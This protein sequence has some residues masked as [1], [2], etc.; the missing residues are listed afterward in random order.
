MH[1]CR[2]RT[3]NILHSSCRFDSI[4]TF[5][6]RF[7]YTGHQL[8]ASHTHRRCPPRT[9]DPNTDQS[10]SNANAVE[11]GSG[12]TIMSYVGICGEDQN[13]VDTD[14][15]RDADPY[16][17]STSLV[18]MRSY[19]EG[20]VTTPNCGN[21]ATTIPVTPPVVE[22]LM[23]DPNDTCMVPVGSYVQ[24]S[25][26]ITST[27]DAST[28]YFAWDRIDP[29]REE[30][31]DRTV[32]RWVP[33]TPYP[34]EPIRYLP[35]LYLTTFET[36]L[37]DADQYEEIVPQSPIDM[38]F[39]FIARTQYSETDLIQQNE[40]AAALAGSFGFTDITLSYVNSDTPLQF[41]AVPASVTSFGSETVTWTGGTVLSP[42]V[43]ILIARNTMQD[44]GAN[45]NYEYN[46][47]V[48]FLEWISIG[49]FPNTGSAS[50]N[51]PDFQNNPSLPVSLMIRSVDATNTDLDTPDCYFFDM[52]SS[53][54]YANGVGEVTVSLAPSAVPTSSP[55]TSVAP[56]IEPT[57]VPSLSSAPS[58]SPT[59]APSSSIAPS[60]SP[61]GVPSSTPTESATESVQPSSS[62]TDSP[63][64]SLVPSVTP[65]GVPTISPS[66]PPSASSHPSSLPTDI[67]TLSSIP[68]SSPTDTPTTS[69]EPSDSPTVSVAPSANSAAPSESP[70]ISS[71][72]SPQP[73]ISP[74]SA[75]SDSPSQSP[76][77]SFNPT[78]LPTDEPSVQPSLSPTREPT[79][80]P[81]ASPTLS[82]QPSDIPTSQPSISLQ[83]SPTPTDIPTTSPSSQPSETPTVSSAPS[84][85]SD[86]PSEA[87]T[88][89]AQPS[90]SAGP[91][92]SPS[93][94]PSIS[95]PPSV[96]PTLNPTESVQPST[97][98]SS[99]PTAVPTEVP[100]IPPTSLPTISPSDQ[101]TSSIAPSQ[102]PTS[103]AAPTI[104]PSSGPTVG[105]LCLEPE[106][107]CSSGFGLSKSAN[108]R[109]LRRKNGK[110]SSKGKS[111]KSN[112]DQDGDENIRLFPI[113]VA[114]RQG[115]KGMG[116][117]GRRARR[118]NDTNKSSKGGK[119]GDGSSM[120]DE[121]SDVVFETI[122]ISDDDY[123]A[124]QGGETSNPVVSRGGKGKSSSLASLQDFT[125]G[126]CEAAQEDDVPEFCL[127]PPICADNSFPCSPNDRRL[128]RKSMGSK[129]KSKG[130]G[131][132]DERSTSICVNG[133]TLCVDIYDPEYL[134]GMGFSCGPCS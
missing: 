124:L 94:S 119:G 126:C 132:Q 78:N 88:V 37:N 91:T 64:L 79:T 74:T 24:L 50:I 86:A 120:D 1:T 117:M 100:S 95:N 89:S 58:S 48:D 103:S 6:V 69:A 33:Q 22:A 43:E 83:P 56:S 106:V 40:Y 31:S 57:Q 13:G 36:V 10:L 114:S 65:T 47:D 101:P 81:S 44:A 72:P 129:S 16:F 115:G 112:N 102:A 41:T 73:S 39:R 133:V 12:V 105:D 118:K 19:V 108:G 92:E 26:R 80:L 52:E 84:S 82:S 66:S 53:I 4:E 113:C 76:T 134:G 29:G 127:G 130:K 32:P 97:S 61:T 99:L 7:N 20:R 70:T 2:L 104:L 85:A 27:A 55:T 63:T 21:D 51:I 75:P 5:F 17:H 67:P 107:L 9:G 8:S 87:P 71:Q 15:Q 30:Y 116:R 3:H 34:D 54:A 42:N 23:P 28:Y 35:N 59:G 46:T 96:T 68:S 121:S 131:S 25:G 128:R 49:T 14:L 110:N 93:V 62:P 77:E 111:K 45:L 125:C 90:S 123:A 18:T 109:G 38:D 11:T 98:P 122:C 60:D